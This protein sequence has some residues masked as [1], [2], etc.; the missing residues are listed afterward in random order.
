MLRPSPSSL[1]PTDLGLLLINSCFHRKLETNQSTHFPKHI[2]P[3]FYTFV[4]TLFLLP[5]KCPSTNP[6]VHKGY[7]QCNLLSRNPPKSL[8]S[9]LNHLFLLLVSIVHYS[10]KMHGILYFITVNYMSYYLSHI[11]DTEK[12]LNVHTSIYHSDQKSAIF[13]QQVL[14]SATLIKFV[15]SYLL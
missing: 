3:Y 9:V 1:L 13:P 6:S 10:R 5:G 11:N 14:M 8:I 2:F 7:V 15:Q 4:L 12:K